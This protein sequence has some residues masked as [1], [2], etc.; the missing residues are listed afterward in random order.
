MAPERGEIGQ[1]IRDLEI[2]N[3]TFLPIKKKSILQI[4]RNIVVK[5]K[6]D[7]VHSHGISSGL[8]MGL[9]CYLFKIPHIVTIHETLTKEM[10]KGL[11]GILKYIVLSILLPLVDVIHYVSEDTKK[12]V[13]SV[14]PILKKYFQKNVVIQNGI[15]VKKLLS[16]QPKVFSK[17]IIIPE[18][19]FLIGYLGR[20][21]PEKGFKYLINAIDIIVKDKKPNK[22]P[23]VLAFGWGAY[24]R[25]YQLMINK[26][27]LD[28]N[29]IFLP[30]SSEVA[31][32]IKGF[33]VVTV[34]SLRESF[35]LVAAETLVAGVPL[36][37]SNCIGLREVIKNSPAIKI[38]PKNSYMLAMALIKEMR[39]PSKN[40]SKKYS[41][42]A[43]ERFDVTIK[44]KLLEKQMIKLL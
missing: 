15:D 21:M 5:K 40:K 38:H 17:S 12:N 42:T 25:E 8:F 6:F 20:F 4:L 16:A 11:K 41:K 26:K 27:G 33:D 19:A 1:L 14:I 10:F 29:F 32:I 24:I 44:S 2:F 37:A 39:F 43:A 23:I 31:S 7:L 9:Y 28:K 18:N 36:I 35:G 22:Q 34:P 3:P 30:F 13:F